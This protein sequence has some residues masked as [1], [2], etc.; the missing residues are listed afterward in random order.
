MCLD[1]A[2]CT[3]LINS[4]ITVLPLLLSSESTFKSIGFS[5]AGCV[6]FHPPALNT[7][8]PAALLLCVGLLLCVFP[9]ELTP[10]MPLNQ[11][12]SHSFN[13]NTPQIERLPFPR[14][15]TVIT[16]ILFEI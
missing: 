9:D 12:Q 11:T 4:Q 7:A 15:I 3:A 14:V 13:N 1:I 10:L 5:L 2:Y 6:P 16:L 8:F